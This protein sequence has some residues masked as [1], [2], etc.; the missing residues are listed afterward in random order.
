MLTIRFDS[1][2]EAKAFVLGLLFGASGDVELTDQPKIKSTKD[3]DVHVIIPS[4][5]DDDTQL[6]MEELA[7]DYEDE[8][9]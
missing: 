4:Y 2:S 8:D 6:D 1:K 9:E 7:A 5:D 3:G